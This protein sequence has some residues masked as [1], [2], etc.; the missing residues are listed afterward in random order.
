M[1]IATERTA[2][3]PEMVE[4]YLELAAMQFTQLQ[5]V[6]ARATLAKLQERVGQRQTVAGR[7]ARLLAQFEQFDAALELWK[8]IAEASPRGEQQIEALL[9]VANLYEVTGDNALAKQ[10]YEDVLTK[11]RPGSWL[12]RN[13]SER[14]ESLFFAA[15]EV[16]QLIESY[17]NHVMRDTSNFAVALRL[18][19]LLAG[20]DQLQEAEDVFRSLIARSPS[21]MEARD[22]LVGVLLRRQD[23]RGAISEL[24]NA[25]ELEP[26]NIDR[27]FRLG[28]LYSHQGTDDAIQEAIKVWEKIAERYKDSSVQLVDV[29]RKMQSVS[30]RKRAI[31]LYE[32]AI[33]LEPDAAQYREYLGQFYHGLGQ[34]DEAVRVWQ[35]IAE[36][37][38]HQTTNLIRLA[39]VFRTFQYNE[40]CLRTWREVVGLDPTNDQRMQFSSLLVE[41][42]L[43]DEAFEQLRLVRELADDAKTL[44]RC[45]HQEIDAYVKSNRLDQAIEE[46]STEAAT[47]DH[48]R[49]FALMS[50]ANGDL[51]QSAVAIRRAVE[52][53]PEDRFI[54]E[55]AANIYSAVDDLE[56]AITAYQKLVELSPS[57]AP[58]YLRHLVA[59]HRTHGQDEDAERVATELVR[60]LPTSLESY[61]LLAAIQND[62]GR[63]P[64]S[65]ETLR[66]ALVIDASSTQTL[67]LLADGLADQY[68]TAEAIELLWQAI[69]HSSTLSSR[70]AIVE[71]LVPLYQRR[72]ELQRLVDRLTQH[73]QLGL[74]NRALLVA[75]VWQSVGDL[76]AAIKALR[77]P[78]W[79]DPGDQDALRMLAGLSRAIADFETAAKATETL[80]RINPTPEAATELLDLRVRTG[81]LS[82]TD[83]AIAQLAFATTPEQSGKLIANELKSNPLGAIAVCEAVLKN[84]PECWDVKVCL[85]QLYLRVELAKGTPDFIAVQQLIDEIESVD[86]EPQHPSPRFATRRL[87]P[88]SWDPGT[89]EGWI[90]PLFKAEAQTHSLRSNDG[91]VLPENYFQAVWIGRRLRLSIAFHDLPERTERSVNQVIRRLF[92]NPVAKL[93]RRQLRDYV[94]Y[95]KL[96][97]YMTSVKTGVPDDVMLRI[98]ELDLQSGTLERVPQEVL[99]WLVDRADRRTSQNP[100]PP[101]NANHLDTMVQLS[102]QRS[103]ERPAPSTEIE[104]VRDSLQFR[105]LLI[106]EARLAGQMSPFGEGRTG[107]SISS[108]LIDPANAE[109]AFNALVHELKLALKFR[110]YSE[111]NRLVAE[112][113]QW[114][115]T[116]S[117]DKSISFTPS[118]QT[119]HQAIFSTPSEFFTEPEL[120][121]DTTILFASRSIEQSKETMP[122][123]L[124]LGEER[125]QVIALDRRRDEKGLADYLFMQVETPFAGRLLS[126]ETIRSLVIIFD[127]SE[128]TQLG[129][130]SEAAGALIRQLDIDQQD[131]NPD[132]QRLRIVAAAFLFWWNDQR[133]EALAMMVRGTER[134]PADLEL[135]IEHARFE[136]MSGLAQEGMARL[137]SLVASTDTE[138]VLLAY[139]RLVIAILAND[140]EAIDAFA[141]ELVGL[142]MDEATM[143]LL[144]E[145]LKAYDSRHPRIVQIRS[146]LA[147]RLE[148]GQSIAD[149]PDSP[150]AAEERFLHAE[151]VLRSGRPVAAAEMAFDIV[152]SIPSGNPYSEHS[153]ESKAIGL[154]IQ[155]GKTLALSQRLSDQFD[156]APSLESLH[157]LVDLMLRTGADANAEQQITSFLDSNHWGLDRHQNYAKR[158]SQLGENRFAAML[159]KVLFDRDP[160]RWNTNGNLIVVTTLRCGI[161]RYQERILQAAKFEQLETGV[162]LSL[163][164]L[165][166]ALTYDDWYREIANEVVIQLN[167]DDV[168]PFAIID[169]IPIAERQNL[170][171]VEQLLD[172]ILLNPTFI[173]PKSPLWLS[174]GFDDDGKMK[175]LLEHVL[176]RLKA[177]PDAS[178]QSGVA[179]HAIVDG[180]DASNNQIAQLIRLLW[181]LEK[182]ADRD[183]VLN[184]LKEMFPVTWGQVDAES[185]SGF[186]HAL[187]WQA[188]QVIETFV[189]GDDGIDQKA[190][191]VLIGVYQAAVRHSPPFWRHSHR[192]K[193]PTDRLWKAYE[194]AER[195]DLAAAAWIERLD[196]SVVSTVTGAAEHRRVELALHVA[197]NLQRL[198]YPAEAVAACAE[199][200]GQPVAVHVASLFD[201]QFDHRG[202][203]EKRQQLALESI[204]SDEATAFLRRLCDSPNAKEDADFRLGTVSLE[205]PHDGAMRNLFGTIC[206]LAIESDTGRDTADRLL[207]L[208][209]MPS[210]SSNAKYQS[211]AIDQLRKAIETHQAAP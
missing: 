125:S 18:G 104:F 88:V 9:Q 127:R 28:N 192:V 48:W 124:R 79:Q 11:V 38:R 208:L 199:M 62:A 119:F 147:A 105:Q 4:I 109:L 171:A 77:L 60:R 86:H 211:V 160:D 23:S 117:S 167:R 140:R 70:I 74:K 51:E 196:E 46:V 166:G 184:R 8:K 145:R 180:G 30:H 21:S 190:N 144:G 61:W 47:A 137:N 135:Q 197:G 43:F 10:T 93:D 138:Q 12:Y 206:S 163:L 159:M 150:S 131:M 45:L 102:L 14:F 181:R 27:L 170:P 83:A 98:A 165:N 29:A 26:G 50:R 34:R 108:V 100:P 194:R 25:L 113:R 3:S 143:R 202:E 32:R 114:L 17:T 110:N 178:D 177:V 66:S 33:E 95:C 156:A 44:N 189:D 148:R 134:F 78:L 121:L 111:A 80:N 81:E 49:R 155:S 193:V 168:P 97:E 63:A 54:W 84:D 13:A 128:G 152:N 57:Q 162:L 89:E 65:E 64:E 130:Q 136:V 149:T 153:I 183:H 41:L 94:Y 53:D 90:T 55:D 200:L 146:G 151:E 67:K 132:E 118:W 35:T 72:D 126:I 209:Q 112:V 19:Q 59:L 99:Q 179:I 205:I 37:P 203:L 7:S 172:G 185:A 15:N 204:D 133:E 73:Q 201:R 40:E 39:E 187:L 186:P 116:R 210:P 175:G 123:T 68:Q 101:L 82:S 188:G 122:V 182:S 5:D 139:A 157:R 174:A 154:L 198:G 176:W 141:N 164:N 1:R 42:N 195:V 142:P 191:E 58:V 161:P 69:D 92:V 76:D 96:A 106:A 158:M 87:R 71:Q 20:T 52:L 173:D 115:R 75:T 129:K 56:H 91:V 207:D 85:A 36:A 22:E 120:I 169:S 107:Q 6:A 31:E 2:T 103:G 24:Q 16:D